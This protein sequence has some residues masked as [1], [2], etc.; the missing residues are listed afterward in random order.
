MFK[1]TTDG[2]RNIALY[3]QMPKATKSRLKQSNLTDKK[4]CSL[5]HLKQSD[6]DVARKKVSMHLRINNN[7]NLP[8]AMCASVQ[9]TQMQKYKFSF[10]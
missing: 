6:L 9:T 5:A 2:K 4:V 3:F 1:N 10:K 7:I 8:I